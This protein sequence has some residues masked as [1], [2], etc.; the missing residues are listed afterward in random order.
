MVGVHG[1]R[2]IEKLVDGLNNLENN[3]SVFLEIIKCGKTAVNPL[4]RLLH[5]PPSVF[6]EPRSLAAEA[7]ALIGGEEAFEGL[8]QV[9]S[10]YDL[11]SLDPEIRLAEETVRNQAARQ[12]RI[13]GDERA[14][15]PLLRCLRENHLRGAAEALASFRDKR[16]IPYLIKMLED[17]YAQDEASKALLCFDKNAVSPLI[18]TL[19][20]K[21]YTRFNNETNLSVKRRAEAARLLGEIGDPSAIRTLIKMLED[22]KWEVRLSSAL[23]LVEIGVSKD[24]IIKVIPELITGLNQGDWYTR[25]LC[26]DS[27][28]EFIS[29]SLLYIERIVNERTVI[30]NRGERIDTSEQTLYYLRGIIAKHTNLRMH[31][32]NLV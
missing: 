10:L 3:T 19:T 12:L 32:F 21:N 15:E 25:N 28:S 29:A 5:S 2:E 9:L 4:V 31:E 18:E 26:I 20:R 23:S 17:D 22:E 16:A 7:L 13:F 24:E 11:N 1:E 14:R 8:I 27:L 6:S 30:N